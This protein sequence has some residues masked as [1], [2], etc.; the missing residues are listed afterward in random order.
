M[1]NFLDE[2][3]L[4][5]KVCVDLL[6]INRFDDLPKVTKTWG[7]E[8][9]IVNTPDYCGKIINCISHQWSSRGQF[10][11]HK[12]KDETFY[13][14]HGTLIVETYDGEMPLVLTHKLVCGDSLRIKPGVRHRFTAKEDI[15]GMCQFAEFSTNHQDSDSYYP[16]A[17]ENEAVTKFDRTELEEED[18]G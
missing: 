4:N 18:F 14:L 13:V 11:Y 6:E 1:P 16:D 12:I 17:Q 7:M 3:E 5:E 10:H 8:Y 15:A 2:N 9:L